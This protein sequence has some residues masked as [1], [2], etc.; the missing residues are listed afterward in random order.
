MFVIFENS[1]LK[2]IE[3]VLW[4]YVKGSFLLTGRRYGIVMCWKEWM[5]HVIKKE[6]WITPVRINNNGAYHTSGE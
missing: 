5:R 3:I 6:Q 4:F 1:S 2:K